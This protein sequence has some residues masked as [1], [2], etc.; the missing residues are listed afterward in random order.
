[1]FSQLL[2]ALYPLLSTVDCHNLTKT[3]SNYHRRAIQFDQG[4]WPAMVAKARA[5]PYVQKEMDELEMDGVHHRVL[6]VSIS[7]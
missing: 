4:G 1:L 7:A 3:G 6:T 5:T 2:V